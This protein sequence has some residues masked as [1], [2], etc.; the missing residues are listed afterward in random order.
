MEVLREV[1]QFKL[2]KGEGASNGL[3]N[4]TN[5]ILLDYTKEDGCSFWFDEETKDILLTVGTSEFIARAKQACGNN[6]YSDEVKQNYW[7]EVMKEVKN[8]VLTKDMVSP[9]G[10]VIFN[11]DTME[12]ITKW[13]NQ[14]FRVIQVND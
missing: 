14:T 2:N 11:G 6:I 10:G 3:Y 8:G 7:N 5:Q 4:L 13:F 1:G 12:K 9:V